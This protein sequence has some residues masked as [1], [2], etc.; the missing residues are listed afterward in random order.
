MRKPTPRPD[1]ETIEMYQHAQRIFKEVLRNN[2]KASTG[3][4]FEIIERII[5]ALEM[6]KEIR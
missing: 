2:P 5:N 4:L 3:E 6:K 1:L